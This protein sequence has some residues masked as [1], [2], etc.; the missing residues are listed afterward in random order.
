[1]HGLLTLLGLPQGTRIEELCSFLACIHQSDLQSVSI[2]TALGNSLLLLPTQLCWSSKHYWI[3]SVQCSP[4][5]TV[6]CISKKLK[7]QKFNQVEPFQLPLWGIPALLATMKSGSIPL[8]DVWALC[9]TSDYRR[10][11]AHQVTPGHW[12]YLKRKWISPW[13]TPFYCILDPALAMAWVQPISKFPWKCLKA[14]TQVLHGATKAEHKQRAMRSVSTR[15]VPCL[16]QLCAEPDR[17]EKWPAKS[18]EA[19]QRALPL[20]FTSPHSSPQH[21]VLTECPF[22]S[23]S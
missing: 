10:F 19:H 4:L 15:A 1:M 16:L 18:D 13:Q 21:T 5:K 14:T 23:R 2:I 7:K 22:S 8:T 20:P 3:P 12:Y 17:S 6:P 9:N 11:W